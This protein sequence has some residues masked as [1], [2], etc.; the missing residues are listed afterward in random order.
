M[1]NVKNSKQ[2]KKKLIEKIKFIRCKTT[3]KKKPF[4]L[5]IVH[6]PVGAFFAVAP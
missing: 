4:N 1:I 6:F 2:Q 5:C 3:T